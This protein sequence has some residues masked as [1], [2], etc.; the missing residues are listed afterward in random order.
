VKLGKVKLLSY[1]IRGINNESI[2]IEEGTQM[3]YI[4]LDDLVTDTEV[5]ELFSQLGRFEPPTDMIANIMQMVSQLPTPKPLS[6]WKALDFL[7]LNF[8]ESQLC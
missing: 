6:T 2:M 8:D 1:V 3:K 4:P 7:E 5:D